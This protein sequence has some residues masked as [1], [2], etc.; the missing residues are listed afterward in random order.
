MPLS[1]ARRDGSGK[2]TTKLNIITTN[3]SRSRYWFHEANFL[4][5]LSPTNPVIFIRSRVSHFSRFH[6]SSYAPHLLGPRLGYDRGFGLIN[7]ALPASQVS[8]VVSP[9]NLARNEQ[10]G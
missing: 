6:V 3:I 5:F 4:L 2:R 7:V 1:E 9:I 8:S 10:T